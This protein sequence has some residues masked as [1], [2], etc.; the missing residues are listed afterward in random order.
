MAYGKDDKRKKPTRRIKADKQPPAKRSDADAAGM[1]KDEVVS[2]RRVGSAETEPLSAPPA[3]EGVAAADSPENEACSEE[4]AG[5]EV[6]PSSAEGGVTDDVPARKT[7]PTRRARPGSGFAVKKPGM[8]RWRKVLPFL[9]VLLLFVSFVACSFLFCWQ[10]WWRYDD[11]ADIKGAWKVEATGDIVVFD[12]RDLKITNT[13][14]YDY[15]LDQQ[16][17]RIWYTFG[18]L[19]GGGRYYFDASRG[20]LVIF[21]GERDLG[22]LAEIGFL[23]GDVLETDTATDEMTVLSK[24]SDDT[25]AVPTGRTSG[26]SG[27]VTSRGERDFVMIP[28]PEPSSSSSSSEK[29]SSSS[30]SD[31]DEDGDSSKKRPSGDSDAEEDEE[32]LDEE[33]EQGLDEEDE[34]SLG[35]EEDEEGYGEEPEGEDGYY[36]EDWEEDEA[37][38]EDD[39]YGYDDEAV[40]G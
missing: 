15:R 31:E 8:R 4:A 5:S 14:S 19:E 24:V 38:Y 10:K 22:L 37:Y 21:D 13:I 18:E 17:K 3:E 40:D 7:A 25:N 1:P 35:E 23:P 26:A 6:E 2:G 28:D 16:G 39:G 32:G 34:E 12:G 29:K 27:G 33:D 30:S 9:V 36:D 20:R 11:A